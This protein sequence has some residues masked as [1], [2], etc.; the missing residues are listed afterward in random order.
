[1]FGA[2]CSG[3]GQAEECNFLEAKVKYREGHVFT[4]RQA[5]ENALIEQKR[6][7]LDV[8]LPATSPF[9][10]PSPSLLRSPHLNL[11]FP[12]CV[13]TIWRVGWVSGQE[14]SRLWV[15]R[16][17]DAEGIPQFGQPT[18][19]VDDIKLSQN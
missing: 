19:R 7:I 16:R 18:P 15:H 3:G 13:G 2:S 8:R 10:S 5:L 9:P 12:S 1:M 14:R 11:T 17:A 6:R 4:A